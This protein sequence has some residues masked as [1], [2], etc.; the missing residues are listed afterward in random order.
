MSVKTAPTGAGPD[1][2]PAEAGPAERKRALPWLSVLDRPLTS[3]HLII[4][5]AGL[6]LAIGLAMVLSTSSASQLDSGGSPYS[7]FVKQLLGALIGLPMVWLLSRIPARVLRAVAYPTLLAA[8]GGLVLVLAFG[9]TVYGAERWIEIGG[10]QVQPSEF[11]KLALLLWGADLLARKERLGQL[12]D[13]RALLIPLL[14]GSAVVVLLVMLGDDLGT[15]FLLLVILLALLWVIGTPGRLLACMIGLIVFALAMLL[16]IEPWRA[17]RL[18][19]YLNPSGG[20]VG[21]NMQSIQGKWAIGSGGWFG[22]GLGDSKQKWGWVPNASNDFIFAILGEELG[23][24]GT[25]CVV[26]L[27]GGLAYGGLRVARR[28]ADPFMRLAAAG[29]TVWIVV[30][31]LVNISAVVGLL[32]ITGVPLPLISQGLS[33]LLVTMAGIGILLGFA[34]REPGAAEALAALGPRLPA[35]I[36]R[37]IMPAPAA[38]AAASASASA[39]PRAARRRAGPARAGA[40]RPAPARPGPAGPGPAGPARPGSAPVRPGPAQGRPRPAGGASAAAQFR[41]PV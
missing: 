15:T 10:I 1:A 12:S 6:L 9:T 35:R 19:G 27:Y 3:Y 4:G 23:L 18:T 41:R 22:V 39:G 16:V 28:M 31:A 32:P 24:I 8:I 11:A 25:V 17:A 21:S 7:V 20:P 29:I 40:A 5:C 37:S 14:P 33:S 30:Q 38:A 13:W 2:S 34:R 26:V 36:I